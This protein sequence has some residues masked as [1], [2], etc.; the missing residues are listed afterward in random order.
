MEGFITIVIVVVVLWLIIRHKIKE[1]NEERVRQYRA[2]EEERLRKEYPDGFS[3]YKNYGDRYS[4]IGVFN[5]RSTEEM[6][7]L[8][9]EII[10]KQKQINAARRK[11]AEEDEQLVER[12]I[13]FSSDCLTAVKTYCQGF[14]WYLYSIPWEKRNLNGSHSKSELSVW[15]IFVDSL[16]LEQDLDYSLFPLYKANFDNLSEFKGMT[17]YWKSYIY[18]AINS[19][20]G[21][22]AKQYTLGIVFDTSIKDWSDDAISFHYKNI[23]RDI[24]NTHILDSEFNCYPFG[25][26]I[27]TTCDVN[28]LLIFSCFTENSSLKNRCENI[29]S[30]IANPPCVVY[31]SLLKCYDRNEMQ[32]LIK[33]E[34]V[35]YEEKQK[36]LK[37]E[38]EERLKKEKKEQIDKTYTRIKE[39][40]P[41]GTEY[42]E[43]FESR[44]GLSQKE[45]IVKNEEEVAKYDKIYSRYLTLK[46]KYPRGLPEFERRTSWDDGK[47]YAGLTIE[48]VIHFEDNISEI[49]QELL[50]KE[51]Q[52]QKEN[53][54]I[55]I[56][57]VKDWDIIQGCLHY[58]YLLN[59]FPVTCNFEA[60]KR[61][62][63]DRWT[64]WNFKNTPGKT[65]EEDHQ[66][67]LEEVIPRIK[68]LLLNTF[69]NTCLQNLTLVCIP[70]STAEKTFARYKEFSDRLCNITGIINAYDYITVIKES[71]EKKFGGSGITTANVSFN[72]DFFKAKNVLLF[73]DIIT[74]GESMLRFKRKMES[75]GATVIGGVSIGKTKHERQQSK[76]I[77]DIYN[78][79]YNDLPF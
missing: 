10:N 69:G 52:L 72:E 56:S 24:P 64:V 33:K 42:F 74:K 4:S 39:Q 55:L 38:E 28:F 27:K 8:K 13:K 51:L 31:L 19:F 14:G 70:A 45:L 5:Y 53:Q 36:Q 71:E 46:K 62:W 50:H 23:S 6:I 9:T 16:C 67:A 68:E 7:S 30:K 65:S 58:T 17:R 35:K 32:E 12:Q 63:E 25:R 54:D 18:E 2:I 47:N 22:L 59:Y 48:E 41:F 79:L 77:D 57:K 15:Q 49:E 1:N 66:E 34:Q 37:Q 44:Y 3:Y 76:T 78:D 75:L 61:E 40:Y 21:E 20:I 29:F 26:N 11:A 60:N 73:D 43:K